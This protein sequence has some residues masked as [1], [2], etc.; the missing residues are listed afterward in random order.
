V[1][2]LLLSVLCDDVR[3]EVGHKH[4]LM[5]LFDTFNLADFTQPLPP[6]HVFA[7]IA[8]EDND[9]HDVTMEL[10][11]HEEDFRFQVPARV[12]ALGRDA[13]TDLNLAT[14]NIGLSGIRVPRPGTYHIVF[15]VDGEELSGP[16][17][18]VRATQPPTLQ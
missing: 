6:F 16:S 13:A 11:S 8:V 7:R 1:P 14:V 18:V 9:P 10:H 3:V 17:F 5:G 4:S 15:R 2:R 12:Q